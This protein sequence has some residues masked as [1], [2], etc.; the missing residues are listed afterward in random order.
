MRDE[1]SQAGR[2]ESGHQAGTQPAVEAQEPWIGIRGRIGVVIPS[3]NIAVEYDCQRLAVPGVTWHFGRFFTPATDLSSDDAFLRFLEGIRDTIPDA[4]QALLTAEIGHLMMGMSSETFWGGVAGNAEFVAKIEQQAGRLGITTGANA[5][6]DALNRFGARRL[7][8][9]T[10]YQPVGDRQV[11]RFFG[12]SGFDVVRIEGLRCGSATSI[13]HTPRGDVIRA[14]VEKLDGDDIDAIVQVGTN[15]STG[16]AFPALEQM[17]AKPCIAIN[18]AT[19]WHALRAIGVAD[20]VAGRG[21][22]LEEF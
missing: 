15:L 17:L 14:V 4:V 11:L 8:V 5:M 20:P 16:D 7:A 22:L 6:I 18:V 2:D 1:S 3:T 12:E 9:L 13:A 21:R 10:P 19:A